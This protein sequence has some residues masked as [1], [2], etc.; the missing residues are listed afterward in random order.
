MIEIIML[1]ISALFLVT[2]VLMAGYLTLIG[3]TFARVFQK[4][5]LALAS[6]LLVYVALNSLTPELISNPALLVWQT[7]GLIFA[8]LVFSL[9]F[10][11][12]LRKFDPLLLGKRQRNDL[13][14]A[15]KK[16]TKTLKNQKVARP[17]FFGLASS[18]AFPL[19][20]TFFSYSISN[21]M[22]SLA[23]IF[24]F[25]GGLNSGLLCAVALTAYLL[26]YKVK[27]FQLMLD[28]DFSPRS[29]IFYQL[30]TFA[31]FLLAVLI[32]S[33]VFLYPYHSPHTIIFASLSVGFLLACAIWAF[34]D[35]F[36]LI[37]R[38]ERD[39][40]AKLL[41]REIGKKVKHNKY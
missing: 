33:L 4:Y 10:H 21:F 22:L 2:V 30:A 7:A 36:S 11:Y 28:L 26:P 6:L 23:L 37:Y 32:F 27:T 34:I 31:P 41:E 16:I 19:K 40:Y 1:Y 15:S 17:E 38:P 20:S 9:F 35:T 29:I 13:R 12:L 14:R 18:N 5:F 8:G 25:S 39:S 3:S 24:S